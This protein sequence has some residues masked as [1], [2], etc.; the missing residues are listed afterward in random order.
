VEGDGAW[1]VGGVSSGHPV[2]GDDLVRV[3][4]AG[5]VSGT[6]RDLYRDLH[7]VRMTPYP[8]GDGPYDRWELAVE[9]TGQVLLEG[10]F[11][12]DRD[13]VRA[14]CYDYHK[15]LHETC[16]PI[17]GAPA[18]TEAVEIERLRAALSKCRDITSDICVVTH[19]DEALA[20]YE[21]VDV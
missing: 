20:R 7:N 10:K 16:Y 3:E 8:I 1:C 15:G 19:V 13:A 5:I 18:P 11:P 21:A 12:M 17:V 4:D 6:Q 14:V 2:S 9:A